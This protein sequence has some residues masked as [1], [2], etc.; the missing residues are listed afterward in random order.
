MAIVEKYASS[1]VQ[2]MVQ[3]SLL[4]AVFTVTGL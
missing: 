4:G 1:L 3:S 2:M